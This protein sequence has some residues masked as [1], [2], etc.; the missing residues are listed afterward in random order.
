MV[1]NKLFGKKKEETYFLEIDTKT[2]NQPSAEVAVNEEDSTVKKST[3]EGKKTSVT[4]TTTTKVDVS[5]DVPDWVKAIKNYSRQSNNNGQEMEGENFAGKYVSNSVP[6]SRRRPGPSL[7]TF[8]NMASK[9][10]R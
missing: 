7:A 10:N 8:K 9:I 6:Q 4:S 2:E 3:T 1:L 5:Y